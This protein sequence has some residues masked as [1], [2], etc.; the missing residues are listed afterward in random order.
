[1]M[2]NVC[3]YCGSRTPKDPDLIQV[4]NQLGSS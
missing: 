3:V 1:M 2:K 4:A